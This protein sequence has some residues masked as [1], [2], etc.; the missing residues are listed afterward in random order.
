MP[1]KDIYHKA[2]VHALTTDGWKITHDP[3]TLSY[4][5][6]DLYVD[7]GAERLLVAAERD[8]KKIAVEIKSFLGKSP[9]RDLEESVGQ[10][11]IYQTILMETEPDRLIYLAVPH[12]AWEGIFMSRF[13]RLIITK[14]NIRIVVFDPQKESIVRWIG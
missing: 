4:G 8:K 1:A 13:G 6:K 5:D 7:I 12:R 11:S 10:Y 9:V 3:L 14:L 2:V